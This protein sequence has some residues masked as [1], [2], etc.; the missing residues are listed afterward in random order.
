MRRAIASAMRFAG[1]HIRLLMDVCK[2][3]VIPLFTSN[4]AVN[5]VP[6]AGGLAQHNVRV[7]I[8]LQPRDR[9]MMFFI[10]TRMCT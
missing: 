7:V 2:L 6:P 10:H 9:L 5:S 3:H 1:R 8:E 4:H